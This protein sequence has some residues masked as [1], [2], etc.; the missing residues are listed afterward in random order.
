MSQTKETQKKKIIATSG[1]G[2]VKQAPHEGPVLLAIHAAEGAGIR[3]EVD[4][5]VTPHASAP[6]F[7]TWRLQPRMAAAW[8][9]RTCVRTASRRWP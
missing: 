6:G 4:T 1:K 2:L 5:T 8:E 3:R 9:E 7:H